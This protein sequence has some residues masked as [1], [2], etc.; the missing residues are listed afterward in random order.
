MLHWM[1]PRLAFSAQLESLHGK[2]GLLSAPLA[3]E[4]LFQIRQ[5]CLDATCAGKAHTLR[6]LQAQPVRAVLH[7]LA[8]TSRVSQAGSCVAPVYLAHTVL[9]MGPHLASSVL[10]DHTQ[11]NMELPPA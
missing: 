11:I 6:S 2:K 9:S 5:A 4:D 7:Q 8:Q 10:L 3:T 1:G